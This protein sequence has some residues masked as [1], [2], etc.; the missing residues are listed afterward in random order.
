MRVL[1]C[2]GTHSTPVVGCLTIFKFIFSLTCL[3]LSFWVLNVSPFGLFT[4]LARKV[5][6]SSS[7]ETCHR[8]DK[9]PCYV[10]NFDGVKNGNLDKHNIRVTVYGI[11]SVKF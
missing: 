6:R 2:T 5:F 11:L 3:R 4:G 7:V 1:S 10:L 8:A 9:P